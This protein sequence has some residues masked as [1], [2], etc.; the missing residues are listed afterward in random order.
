MAGDLVSEERWAAGADYL[1]S[2][3]TLGLDPEALF[4]A[5]R[6]GRGG[7]LALILISSIVDRVGSTEIYDTLFKAYDHAVTPR[8]IDPWIVSLFSPD[9]VLYE[10]FKRMVGINFSSLHPIV[11]R[12]GGGMETFLGIA[13]DEYI[14]KKK[15]VYVSRVWKAESNWQLLVWKTFQHN[16]DRLAA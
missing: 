16:V 7:E 5:E 2:L 8:S 11:D 14:T 1:E 15:W 4:W 9:T 3:K 6:T 13:N 10:D 12:L